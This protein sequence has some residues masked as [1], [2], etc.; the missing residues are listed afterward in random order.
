[1]DILGFSDKICE[2]GGLENIKS[3]YLE[4][5]ESVRQINEKYKEVI[6]KGIKEGSY[7]AKNNIGIFYKTNVLYGS[8]SI[9]IWSDRTWEEFKKVGD[10][11]KIHFTSKWLAFP[12]ACDPF[13]EIC[14]EIICKSIE[15]DLPLRGA[16]SMGDGYFDFE[17]QIFI[18]KPIIEAVKLEKFQNIIGASFCHSFENQTIPKRFYF[19]LDDYLKTTICKEKVNPKEFTNQNVLDWPRYWRETRKTDLAAAIENIDFGKRGD[20]KENTLRLIQNAEQCKDNYISNE[21]TDI[22]S[23]YKEYYNNCG[24]PIRLMW[25]GKYWDIGDVNSLNSYV[26]K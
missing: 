22:Q 13:I 6:S 12:K 26:A 16:L 3:K 7:W 17:K 2:E 19:K 9:I 1:L 18:G 5:T 23:V 11:S 4:L 20:I 24:L 8:D 14:N 21:E 10:E 15:L 25:N